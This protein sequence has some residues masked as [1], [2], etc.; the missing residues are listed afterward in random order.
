MVWVRTRW[1]IHCNAVTLISAEAL[2]D[3]V[4]GN[5]CSCL[6]SK[7]QGKSLVKELTEYG[8]SYRSKN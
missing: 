8:K 4:F 5:A 2:F 1:Q 6:K 3:Y 7:Y